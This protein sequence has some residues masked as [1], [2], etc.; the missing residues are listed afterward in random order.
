MTLLTKSI[1]VLALSA[2]ITVRSSEIVSQHDDKI[3]PLKCD[4]DYGVSCTFFNVQATASDGAGLTKQ[5]DYYGQQTAGHTNGGNGLMYPPEMKTYI[6]F[7]ESSLERIPAKLFNHY[8][9]ALEI[10][11]RSVGL[12]RLDSDSFDG[13]AYLE[14]IDLSSNQLTQVNGD[15]F[16]NLSNVRHIDLSY[17]TIETID[18][19]AFSHLSKLNYVDLTANCMAQ[20]PSR[21]FA[22]LMSLEVVALD[23]N[24][25]KG[26]VIGADLFETNIN[27]VYVSLQYNQLTQIGAATFTNLTKL[28]YLRLSHNHL[29]ELDQ[30][31]LFV[32]NLYVSH[33]D[34]ELFKITSNIKVL[35][36]QHNQLHDL[37]CDE[38]APLSMEILLLNNN[39]LNNFHCVDRMNELMVLNMAAND[40]KL[41]KR[42]TFLM[43]AKLTTLQLENNKI[44]LIESGALADLHQL[45]YLDLSNNLLKA[46]DLNLIPTNGSLATFFVGGNVIQDDKLCMLINFFGENLHHDI[47]VAKH[48]CSLEL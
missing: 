1:S 17:N 7:V 30:I 40:I 12:Q 43:V 23:H 20:L 16:Q 33:N 10:V 4:N 41:I 18:G 9:N 35:D 24:Q 3:I 25:L 11:A 13:A 26:A 32:A 27:L 22:G 31:N 37:E 46:F 5:L 19:D 8:S 44:S 15:V 2:I 39:H 14:T 42:S 38:V 34:L 21:I 29:R 6:E 28:R 48:N 45:E 36:A 47:D